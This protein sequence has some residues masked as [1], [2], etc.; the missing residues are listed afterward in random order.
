MNNE[1]SY[2]LYRARLGIVE[3]ETIDRDPSLFIAEITRVISPFF[4]RFPDSTEYLINCELMRQYS[5]LIESGNFD[6]LL[7]LWLPKFVLY[8]I[9]NLTSF[10]GTIIPFMAQ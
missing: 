2:G 3:R 10:Y 6:K 7:L 8:F 5:L 9:N 1:P 4:L